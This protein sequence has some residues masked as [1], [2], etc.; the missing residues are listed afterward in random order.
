MAPRRRGGYNEKL[1]FRPTSRRRGNVNVPLPFMTSKELFEGMS[2]DDIR[3][4]AS[5]FAERKYHRDAVIFREGAEA[6]DLLVVKSGLVKLLTLSE[7]GTQ[8]ILHIL[9]PGDVFGELI[10]SRSQ[11]PFTAI[12]VTDVV[13]ASLR[14]KT[15]LDL[16]SVKADFDRNYTK[17]IASRLLRVEREFAGLINAWAHHRLAKELLHLALDLGV[18][19]PPWT[20]IDLL[21]THEDLSNL[22]GTSRETVTLTL[23]KFERMGMIRREGRH[24]I[25]NRPRLEDYCRLEEP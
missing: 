7:K 1:S 22:I 12:A 11:R 2:E 15:L 10:V 24:I 6:E 20:A 23:H 5:L 14:R 21:L 13:V 19:S 16:L 4:I 25:V 18:D 8:S 9:R 17:M 3:K